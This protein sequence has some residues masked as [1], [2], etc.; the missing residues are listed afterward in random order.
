[1]PRLSRRLALLAALVAPMAIGVVTAQAQP[2]SA[3][4][5]RGD[6]ALRAAVA[7]ADRPAADTKR[8]A[9]RHPAETL[10]FWG[11]KPG[12]T[13][14]DLQPGGGYYTAIVAPYAA[15][16]GGRYIAGGSE[17]GRAPFT[18]KFADPKWGKVDYVAF[19]KGSP[20]YAAPGTA[21]LI[22][23]AREMH[24]WMRG[25]FMDEG[26][27]W[28]FAALKPGGSFAIEEHRADGS[29]VNADGSQGYVKTADVIAAAQKAGFKLVAKSEI[30]ANAK[31][32]KDHPFG[33]WTLPP[34]RQS[35]GVADAAAKPDPTFD[36]AKY[37]AIGES[38]RMTL[39]FV[40]PKA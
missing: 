28:S 1:M 13:V 37:D 12:E 20:A 4:N 35:S 38:D 24:N 31:D 18:G 36:H 16:T 6:P 21:D 7:S 2:A 27:A 29:K 14:I 30:N 23:S 17:R 32:T 8:D 10:L 40:K 5:R 34:S 22:I 33:V 3:I 26:M 11:L 19:G 39:R 25:A 9:D 15:K